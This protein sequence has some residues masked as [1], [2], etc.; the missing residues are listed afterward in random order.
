M[1]YILDA[2]TI[3]APHEIRESNSTQVAVQRTLDGSINRDYFGSNKRV[4]ELTYENV[5]PTDY[6]TIKNIYE[7]YLN[8][9]STKSFQI[10]ESNYSVSSIQV[11]VD[12]EERGFTVRGSSYISSFTVV[13]SEA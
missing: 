11:H 9:G 7:S 4:F 12:L 2:V 5:K 1:A 10:T 6:T 8:T 13:L 3:R